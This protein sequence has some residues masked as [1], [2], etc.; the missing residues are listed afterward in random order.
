MNRLRQSITEYLAMRRSLGFKL[1]DAAAALTEFAEFM[2]RNQASYVTQSL[3]HTP[4][5]AAGLL[6]ESPPSRTAARTLPVKVSGYR[7]ISHGASHLT[8][9]HVARADCLDRLAA[10]PVAIAAVQAQA[11]ARPSNPHQLMSRIDS[12]YRSVLTAPSEAT[13]RARKVS[14]PALHIHDTT[15]SWRK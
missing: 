7:K 4:Q 6:G 1:Q 10:L 14:L 12:D 2:A 13:P 8:C 5:C 11:L 15:R 3:A 9:T